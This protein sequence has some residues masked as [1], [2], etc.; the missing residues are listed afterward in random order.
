MR[1]PG[2]V[3]S[4]PVLGTFW[5]SHTASVSFA[6]TVIPSYIPLRKLNACAE[7]GYEVAIQINII[8][9][10]RGD[11]LL[12]YLYPP[13][14]HSRSPRVPQLYYIICVVSFVWKRTCAFWIEH[15]KIWL[16][17]IIFCYH[18]FDVMSCKVCH[19]CNW[20]MKCEELRRILVGSSAHK[21]L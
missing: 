10:M 18:V 15:T 12:T 9:Y 21:G 8:L 13:L 4:S 19:Y 16:R 5:V 7:Y 1:I 20:I 17:Y 6:S 14:W 11:C 2:A 3:S